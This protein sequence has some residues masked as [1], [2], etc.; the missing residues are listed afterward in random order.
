MEE[1]AAQGSTGGVS[2]IFGEGI[3]GANG[4]GFTPGPDTTTVQTSQGSGTILGDVTI[5]TD[6]VRHYETKAVPL[7]MHGT[8]SGLTFRMVDARMNTRPLPPIYNTAPADRV[9]IE[10]IDWHSLAAGEQPDNEALTDIAPTFWQ[11][12][13]FVFNS[14]SSLQIITVPEPG[15]MSLTLLGLALL[16]L[17]RRR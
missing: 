3:F 11:L 4:R 17:R 14:S 9:E 6:P 1:A 2:T 13:S 10:V 5:V 8:D 12:D 16:V 7:A 15:R